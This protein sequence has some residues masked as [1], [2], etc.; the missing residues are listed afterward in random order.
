MKTFIETAQRLDEIERISFD[1]SKKVGSTRD[2]RLDIE[3][4]LITKKGEWHYGMFTH[5]KREPIVFIG[6]Y[7]KH[8]KNEFI[9]AGEIRL[10]MVGNNK[11]T[12]SLST[13]AGVFR[14]KGIGKLLYDFILLDQKMILVSGFQQSVGGRKA[15]KYLA[16]NKKYLVWAQQSLQSK[17]RFAVDISPDDFEVDGHNFTVY[18]SSDDVDRL[19]IDR[20]RTL[21]SLAKRY[22]LHIVSLNI[23]SV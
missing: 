1:V 9:T 15:W 19:E 2:H 10:E 12:V 7:N 3:D 6:K 23:I 5:N 11:Y 4:K 22:G 14:G 21:I 20:D 18:G 8:R 17:K 13:L 16:G